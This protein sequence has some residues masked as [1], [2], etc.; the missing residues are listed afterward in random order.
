MRQRRVASPSERPMQERKGL[1]LWHVRDVSLAVPREWI[2]LVTV[3]I[4]CFRKN[5]PQG[6][7]T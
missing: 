1:S 3:R 4:G 6:S 5:H 2:L 7:E